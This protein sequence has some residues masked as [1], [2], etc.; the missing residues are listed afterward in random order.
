MFASKNPLRPN[1]EQIFQTLDYLQWM[2][3]EKLLMELAVVSGILL[4]DHGSF[5]RE[6]STRKPWVITTNPL[7]PL[8]RQ[9]SRTSREWSVMFED[10]GRRRFMKRP[11]DA[12]M[13]ASRLLMKRSINP[14]RVC[15]TIS[16][17]DLDSSANLIVVHSTVRCKSNLSKSLESP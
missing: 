4:L 5:L 11:C 15:S 3:I 2:C 8:S 6:S 9:Y 14:V 7:F 12:W 1:R 16:H 17:E 13:S 10:S